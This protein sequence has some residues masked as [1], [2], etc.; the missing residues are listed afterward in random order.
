MSLR[1]SARN[2][3]PAVIEVQDAL[4]KKVIANGTSTET[5]G[6]PQGEVDPSA[7]LLEPQQNTDAYTKATITSE[8]KNVDSNLASKKAAASKR[9]TASRKRKISEPAA[10]PSI[11]TVTN[12]PNGSKILTS[13]GTQSEVEGV[14]SM[15]ATPLPKQRRR[16]AKANT[17][18]PMKSIPFTP[19][20]SGVGLIAG[21]DNVLQ[22]N[23]KA[24]EDHMFDSLA[25][26][27]RNRPAAPDVTNAPVLTPNHSQV[28]VNDSPSKKRKTNDL[29]PDVGSPM[30]STSTIDT[31][32]KDAEAYLVKVDK[33]ITRNGRLQRLIAGHQCKMFNPEGLREVVDPFTALASGII[34]QQVCRVV[35]QWHV[36][37]EAPRVCAQAEW[38]GDVDCIDIY[39]MTTSKARIR[40]TVHLGLWRSSSL[41][42]QEVH[43]PI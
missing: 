1:R 19:T 22:T 14:N 2:A 8:E 25:A 33:E 42:P 27:N 39:D 4:Y 26:L 17:V 29:P 5:A 23:V 9:A 30:K 16:G 31:L 24:K 3:K 7:P 15:P 12:A 35:R 11:G 32:L 28:V 20:P 37:C 36:Q 40:L 10:E 38:D 43:R 34:G 21:R 13:N 18:S 41:D 6:S